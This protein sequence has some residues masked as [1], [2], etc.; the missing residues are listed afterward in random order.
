M[1]C[2]KLGLL[3]G[4]LV[5]FTM[6]CQNTQNLK[7]DS[8]GANNSNSPS[9]IN[10]Q[11]CKAYFKLRQY[12]Q[13]LRTCNKSLRQNPNNVEAHK[14]IA[15]LHQ[16]LGQDT[17]A[18]KHFRTAVTLSPGDSVARNNYGVYLLYKKQY[19]LAEKEFIAAVGNPLYR[20]RELAYVNAGLCMLKAGNKEKAEI[21]YRQALKLNS[22]FSPALYHLAKISFENKKYG[23]ASVFI[24]RWSKLNK[25]TSSTLWIAIQ[26]AKKRHQSGRAA[27]LGLLL[28]NQYPSSGETKLYYLKYGNS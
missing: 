22:R 13:S 3:Y 23:K 27:S 18:E 26:V 28:K 25:W 6:S 2:F 9:N 10:A 12:K 24:K 5:I 20:A 15:V 1:K 14:W 21:Y 11:L 4:L 19:K 16:R 17:L 8:D 7:S